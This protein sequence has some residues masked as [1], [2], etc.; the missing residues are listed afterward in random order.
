MSYM[1]I[2]HGIRDYKL[3]EFSGMTCENWAEVTEMSTSVCHVFLRFGQQWWL[4]FQTWLP[5]ANRRSNLIK[6]I[7]G[8]FLSDLD[9]LN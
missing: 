8:G 1:G 3:G 5:Y 9:I 6:D 4:K 2:R 7:G